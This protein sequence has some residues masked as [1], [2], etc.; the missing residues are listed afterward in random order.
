MTDKQIVFDQRLVMLDLSIE[1]R[2]I[3]RRRIESWRAGDKEDLETPEKLSD[4]DAT[5]RRVA[6]YERLIRALRLGRIALPDEEA[7]LRIT[8]AARGF[9][10]AEEWEERRVD[11]DSLWSLVAAVEGPVELEPGGGSPSTSS[12]DDRA[13]ESAVMRRVLDVH[14][15]RLSE[16]EL[17]LELVGD[18]PAFGK[19]DAVE[20]AARDLAS[21]GLLDIRD[22]LIAPTRAALRSAELQGR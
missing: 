17:A 5:R 13:M 6:A 9:D 12:E 18:D 11:H 22:E 4:P 16:A 1:H 21:I 14:P 20:R 7:R 8:E 15:V 3:L 19:R 2:M 10:D